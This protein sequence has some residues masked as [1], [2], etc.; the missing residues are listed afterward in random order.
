MFVHV[1]IIVSN[2]PGN[3]KISFE[4]FKA[5]CTATGVTLTFNVQRLATGSYMSDEEIVAS[6]GKTADRFVT[7]WRWYYFGDEQWKLFGTVVCVV[8]R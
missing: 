5:Q 7:Q 3:M 4:T 1:Q 8:Y 2:E 6:G